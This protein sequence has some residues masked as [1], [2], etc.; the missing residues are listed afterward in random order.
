VENNRFLGKFLL[1]DLGSS[2]KGDI[3]IKFHLDRNGLLQVIATDIF[4]GKQAN[5]TLKRISHLRKKSVNLAEIESVH[6]HVETKEDDGLKSFDLN[7]DVGAKTETIPEDQHVLQQA[8]TLLNKES[9]DDG[10]RE[11]LTKIL[12]SAKAGDPSAVKKLS[13][14]I[15]YIA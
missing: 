9:L 14:L 12:A 3:H 5:Q 15:Y 11:E 7:D 4:S 2:E 6:I 10:D 13:E 8:E 1:E